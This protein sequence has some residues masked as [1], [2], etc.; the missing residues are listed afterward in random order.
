MKSGSVGD[1]SMTFNLHGY[2]N[3]TLLSQKY[4][5]IFTDQVNL[6]ETGTGKIYR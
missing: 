6:C 4:P 2:M 5:H 3:I 1:L